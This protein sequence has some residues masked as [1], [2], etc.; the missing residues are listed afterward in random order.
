MPQC[1]PNCPIWHVDPKVKTV[2]LTPRLLQLSMPKLNHADHQRNRDSVT[3]IISCVYKT[4]R[5]SP[6]LIQLSLP[7]LKESNVCYEFGCAEEPIRTVSRAARRATASARI[8]I[9][10][11][12]KQLTEGYIPPRE[13]EWTRQ[14]LTPD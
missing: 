2:T 11:Q 7:K 13:P 6:R 5:V 12:P 4:A 10:A 3:S 8:K 9:L 1:E 14:N